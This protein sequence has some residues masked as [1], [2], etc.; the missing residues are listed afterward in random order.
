MGVFWTFVGN[1]ANKKSENGK[2]S[3]NKVCL[4]KTYRFLTFCLAKLP[5]AQ[6]GPMGVFWTFVGNFANK[7]SENGKCGP[8]GVHLCVL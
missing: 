7:K 6:C 4:P 5:T 1:F 8:M 3:V 2:F